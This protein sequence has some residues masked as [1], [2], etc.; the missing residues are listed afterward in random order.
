[1]LRK[2][3]ELKMDETAKLYYILGEKNIKKYI[4]VKYEWM[5]FEFHK[6][7]WW[8]WFVNRSNA[9]GFGEYENKNFYDK[10]LLIFQ[11]KKTRLR[12]VSALSIHVWLEGPEFRS[13]YQLRK[14]AKL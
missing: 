3:M 12:G 6:I 11:F 10:F 4:E 13:A 7:Q 8:I 5:Y 1:M 9:E 2:G 14:H